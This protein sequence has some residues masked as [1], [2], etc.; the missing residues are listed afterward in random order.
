M[1]DYYANPSIE[2]ILK[3]VPML[4]WRRCV[5]CEYVGLYRDNMLPACK[6]HACGSADT[7]AITEANK[8]LH[9]ISDGK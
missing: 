3:A 1:D 6:C 4:Q 5:I 7:R 8:I 2:K 9:R